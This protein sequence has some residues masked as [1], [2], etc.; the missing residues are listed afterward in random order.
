VAIALATL[1]RSIADRLAAL[2]DARPVK[3]EPTTYAA[4]SLAELYAQ[5][6]RWD[7]VIELTKGMANEDDASG[8]FAHSVARPF[9]EQGFH[10]A[11]HLQI[12]VVD[13]DEQ[14]GTVQYYV[15]PDPGRYEWR[16]RG[17]ERV[18]YDRFDNVYFPHALVMDMM[19]RAM[20]MTPGPALGVIPD[21]AASARGDQ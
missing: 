1:N 17:S 5:T 12:K 13:V 8:C 6:G 14:A 7:D 20:Q 9:R 16:D 11:V 19:K 4:V 10:D 3:L 18:L 21:V 15:Q 2:S